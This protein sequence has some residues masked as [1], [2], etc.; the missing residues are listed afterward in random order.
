MPTSVAVISSNTLSSQGPPINE[1][2]GILQQHRREL[3]ALE[4]LAMQAAIHHYAQRTD[5]VGYDICV[6]WH[7]R[8]GWECELR[9][10]TEV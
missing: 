2:A 6:R 5:S 3:L 10:T 8:H 4:I 1:W 7:T 9:D